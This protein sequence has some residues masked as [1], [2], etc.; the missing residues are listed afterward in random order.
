MRTQMYSVHD[1]IAG[2]FFNPFTMHNDQV[3]ARWFRDELGEPTSN[4][5]RHPADFDLVLLG[6][7]DQETGQIRPESDPRIV[8]CGADFV[9]M[10]DSRE[11]TLVE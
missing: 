1:T 7:F 10:E 5:S 3:A 11:N 9:K 6:D 8:M 4:L 2:T